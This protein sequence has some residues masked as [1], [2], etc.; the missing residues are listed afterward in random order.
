MGNRRRGCGPARTA[1]SWPPREDR[2]ACACGHGCLRSINGRCAVGG[3]AAGGG[4]PPGQLPPATDRPRPAPA[5]QR[6]TAIPHPR[7][8]GLLPLFGDA[9]LSQDLAQPGMLVVH[10]WFPSAARPRCPAVTVGRSRRW[11]AQHVS[12]CFGRM[13]Q[14]ATSIAHQGDEPRS[15]DCDIGNQIGGAGLRGGRLAVSARP[16]SDRRRRRGRRSPDRGDG[17]GSGARPGW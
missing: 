11:P 3:L 4:W 16:S 17:A 9:L 8:G 13:R 15:A 2:C 7:M 12:H 1:R 10:V 5:T 6:A 14:G